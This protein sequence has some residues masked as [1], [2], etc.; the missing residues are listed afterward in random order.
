[1]FTRAHRTLERKSEWSQEVSHER[2][3]LTE[4]KRRFSEYLSEW[5]NVFHVHRKKKIGEFFQLSHKNC[6][7]NF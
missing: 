1:M 6:N 2:K 5:E 7:G 3:A 4:E